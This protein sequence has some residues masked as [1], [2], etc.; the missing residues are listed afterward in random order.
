MRRSL[1]H[2]QRCET[3]EET[4][5]AAIR[6]IEEAERHLIADNIRA[7]EAAL[8]AIVSAERALKK[9]G[10]AEGKVARKWKK[11]FMGLGLFFPTDPTVTVEECVEL[12]RKVLNELQ[13]LAADKLSKV[14]SKTP[15]S[16]ETRR[17]RMEAAERK[18]RRR[19]VER[20][21]AH[22]EM[23]K[24]IDRQKRLHET[25]AKLEYLKIMLFQDGPEGEAI[26]AKLIRQLLDERNRLE[27]EAKQSGINGEEWEGAG[28]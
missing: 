5:Q 20:K 26:R 9:I 28:L 12:A 23:M 24:M 3:P 14:S 8:S 17:L 21:F 10:R 13:E 27:S 18:R 25:C 11:H 22:A 2:R 15:L 4:W 6:S 1:R 16:P 7:Y 19:E